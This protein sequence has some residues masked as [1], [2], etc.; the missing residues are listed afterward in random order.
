MKR[1]EREIQN[2]LDISCSF[3]H[4]NVLLGSLS[5][6][7]LDLRRNQGMVLSL[8]CLR[9]HVTLISFLMQRRNWSLPL[10]RTSQPWQAA[11]MML[12]LSQCDCCVNSGYAWFAAPLARAIHYS[13]VVFAQ[14]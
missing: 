9:K 6:R 8:F 4:I 5:Q 11:D 10:Q 1:E 7:N 13:A 2:S 14:Y 3:Y 12:K